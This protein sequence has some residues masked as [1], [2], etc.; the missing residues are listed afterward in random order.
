MLRYSEASGC[1]GKITSRA[2]EPPSS[3]D[4]VATDQMI[5]DF[6]HQLLHR[7]AIVVAR[8][9]RMHLTPHTPLDPVVVRAVRRQEVQPQSLSMLGQPRLRLVRAVD[10]VVVQ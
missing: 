9:I 7:S 6:A 10:L 4:P 3:G 5:R 8:D 2:P 1:H